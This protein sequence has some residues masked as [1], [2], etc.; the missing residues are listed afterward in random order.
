MTNRPNGS[1][2]SKFAHRRKP[3]LVEWSSL[4]Q[5][6]AYCRQQPDRISARIDEAYTAPVKSFQQCEPIV[7]NDDVL[8]AAKFD[9]SLHIVKSNQRDT[10]KTLDARPLCAGKTQKTGTTKIDLGKAAFCDKSAV[11]HVILQVTA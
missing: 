11:E 1:L 3:D 9:I 4:N 6:T 8:A 5:V 7:G 10:G 2:P